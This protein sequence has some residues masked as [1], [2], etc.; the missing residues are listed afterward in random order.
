M[1]D[2]TFLSREL[3]TMGDANKAC[4]MS[5]TLW[6]HLWIDHML[7][8]ARTCGHIAILLAFKGEGLHPTCLR[9]KKLYDPGVPSGGIE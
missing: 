7:G 4:G 3:K 2:F 9:G 6:A 5:I 1:E 8:W